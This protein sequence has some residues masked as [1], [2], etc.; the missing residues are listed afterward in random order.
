MKTLN[1]NELK[2]IGGGVAGLALAGLF[3]G[4]TAGLGAFAAHGLP[5][6]RLLG[7][8]AFGAVAVLEIPAFAAVGFVAGSALN[9][10][11]KEPNV[12]EYS[13]D[14]GKNVK[15]IFSGIS[16]WVNSTSLN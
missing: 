6:N 2:T 16:S 5:G 3:L 9:T 10:V 8:L 12:I 4:Y 1:E 13:S 7:V 14:F 11:L 15:N